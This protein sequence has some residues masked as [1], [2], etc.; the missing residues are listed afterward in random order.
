LLWQAVNM[1]TE[2][3]LKRIR[4]VKLI[5]LTAYVLSASLFQ[6]QS[7]TRPTEV[8]ARTAMALEQ[9]GQTAQAELAWETVARAHPANADA[10]AHVGFLAA[11]LEHYD[12]AIPAYRKALAL[13]AA[14]PGLR[15]NLGLAL[16]S[17]SLDSAEALR[18][19][20]L[21]GIAHYGLG[22]YAAA[23]PFLREATAHDSQNLPFRL[24]LAH[25]CLW[26]KQYPCV[27]EVYHQIL[28]LNAESAEADMLAG[29]ALDEMRDHTGAI[30][31][32][33]AAVKANPH[34]PN[35]HF[36]LGYLLWSQNQLDEAASEFQAELNNVP[37]HAEAMVL[38]ADANM[39][40]G[41]PDGARPLLMKALTID[42][43]LERAHLDLGILA[44]DAN[45]SQEALREFQIA[46]QQ[47]PDDVSVHW[48]LARLYQS[49][50][51]KDEAK[52]EFETT[53]KLHKAASE[54]VFRK[55]HEAQEREQPTPTDAGVPRAN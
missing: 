44:V 28:E 33:R 13:N 8:S 17:K 46:A 14:M 16:E 26:S 41:H 35:V 37:G 23:I 12:A 22:E 25:S 24:L 11:R 52:I 20:T 1:P 51:R 15:L 49:M 40:Q 54:T 48:R 27:L 55:L 21:T 30:Q 10:W 39:Q 9:Q 34:E 18:L 5:L 6:A 36:G 42:P 47:A 38:L 4:I 53:N 31:Q 43:S 45:Q 2:T 3:G 29:E 7:A 50:G 32:F 19:Q